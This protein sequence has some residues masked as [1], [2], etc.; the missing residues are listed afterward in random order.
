MNDL[1]VREE[2]IGRYE[3]LGERAMTSVVVA[4]EVPPLCHPLGADNKL[5]IAPGL[6]SGTPADMTGRLSIG[7]KSSLTGGIK[8]TNAG[9]SAA[10]VL[11]RL[12]YAAL[13]IE[14]TPG[15]N[16]L[17]KIVINRNGVEVVA[18]NTLRMLGNYELVDTVLDRFSRKIACIS[19]GPVGEVKML[20]ASIACTDTELI[21][22]R[23]AGRG[24][25][26]AVM[27]SKGVKI[28]VLDGEGTGSIIARNKKRFAIAAQSFSN[29]LKKDPTTGEDLPRYG[30]ADTVDMVNEIGGF[31]TRYFSDGHFENAAKINAEALTKLEEE[32]GGK[33]TQGCHVS[34]IV[35]CSGIYNDRDGDYITKQPEYETIWSHGANCGIDDMDAIAQLDQLDDDYGIDTLEMGNAIA[36]AMSAGLAEFGDA[37]RAIELVDEVGKGTHLGRILGAGAAV[38]G[39]ILGLE[40][41]A[42]V[43]GQALPVYDPR[44]LQGLGVTFATSPMGADHTAGFV[45][46]TVLDNKG[47]VDPKKI[48]E[49]VKLSRDA[50]IHDA[51]LD[52][53]GMCQFIATAIDE[54]PETFQALLDLINSLYDWKMTA[55]DYFEMGRNILRTERKFNQAAGFSAAHDRLPEFFRN[56]PVNPTNL[57]F[58]V[59][60]SDLDKMFYDGS[61]T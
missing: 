14:G 35:R 56:D 27:G 12:G 19:I 53:T 61:E 30:T 55:E 31:P 7:F 22:N 32:R 37:E 3:G 28:I 43:K 13:V 15:N 36:V 60:D 52:A 46:D 11:A 38:A 59:D 34:C 1:T 21:P 16:D 54:Q 26:G 47:A 2:P 9:G 29:G 5:V 23:H 42:V 20:S 6:L 24:G 49:Q 4:E 48:K 10:Q 40:K 33:I 57:T 44:V 17:H 45:F 25:G 18:D 50:Q 58:Q 41:I 8:E 39:K 51:A